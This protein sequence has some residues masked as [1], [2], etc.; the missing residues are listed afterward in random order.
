MIHFHK[1]KIPSLIYKLA[2]PELPRATAKITFLAFEVD[3]RT[4]SVISFLKYVRCH[5]ITNNPPVAAI[6]DCAN[7]E[8]RLGEIF[9]R[10]VSLAM[11][12]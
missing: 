11:L 12:Y 7:E 5:R 3:K 9:V 4:G 2:P 1:L 6:R 8:D 10:K